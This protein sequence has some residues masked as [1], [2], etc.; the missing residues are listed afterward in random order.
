MPYML[1]KRSI[2]RNGPVDTPIEPFTDWKAAW[3]WVLDMAN[4]RGYTIIGCHLEPEMRTEPAYAE[5]FMAQVSTHVTY[6]IR[7]VD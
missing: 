2:H 3:G 6:V 4:D 1:Y 5:I 7:H